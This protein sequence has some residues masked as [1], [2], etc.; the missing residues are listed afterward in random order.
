MQS[1]ESSKDSNYG[2]ILPKME[3][4]RKQLEKPDF[5]DSGGIV[6]RCCKKTNHR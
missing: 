1:K 5:T 2:N 3:K 4:N 6:V